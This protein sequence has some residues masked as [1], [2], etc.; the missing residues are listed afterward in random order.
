MSAA[1]LTSESVKLNSHS[2]G[3]MPLNNNEPDDTRLYCHAEHAMEAVMLD[4]VLIFIGKEYLKEDD[5]SINPS[6]HTDQLS[7]HGKSV[8]TADTHQ[9]N[10]FKAY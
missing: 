2:N 8:K 10:I 5:H 3:D 6:I 4:A 7:I 1:V 9:S